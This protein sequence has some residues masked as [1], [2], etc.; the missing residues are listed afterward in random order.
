MPEIKCG[1]NIL[2]PGANFWA[3][4]SVNYPSVPICLM[5]LEPNELAG[6]WWQFPLL[7]SATRVS[8]IKSFNLWLLILVYPEHLQSFTLN[9]RYNVKVCRMIQIETK[10]ISF[11]WPAPLSSLSLAFLWWIIEI[12]QTC[13]NLDT[14]MSNCI[15]DITLYRESCNIFHF[16]AYI[17]VTS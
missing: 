3:V 15:S 5:L 2:W 17:L 14:C 1:F 13:S 4:K 9:I 16:I 7:W 12:H 6:Q 10:R 11:Q 8:F